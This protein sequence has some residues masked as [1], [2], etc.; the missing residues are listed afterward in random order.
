MKIFDLGKT[1]C[2]RFGADR[3]GHVALIFALAA[4]PMLG[5]VGLGI[6]YGNSLVAQ[7]RLNAAADQAALAGVSTSGNPTM[8]LP[9]Q[10]TIA[11][12][13]YGTAGKIP[14]VTITNLTVNASTSA[15]SLF[16]TVS[17]T[18]TVTTTLSQVMGVHS[19]TISGTSSAEEQVPQYISFYLLLDV[20]GSMGIPSTS[21]EIAR[22]AAINP[23]YLNL[24]PGGCSLACH[25]TAYKA[26][27]NKQGATTTCQGYNLSRTAGG[28]G[29][30]VSFCPQP[31][32]SSCIQLRLDAVAYAVQQLLSFAKQT[33]TLPNQFAVGLYPFI[34]YM[35]TYQALSTNLT[36]VSTAAGSLTT[37][38]DNGNG[39]SSLGS[40]GTHFENAL[41]ELNSVITK[42]GNGSS[43]SSPLPYVF[44]VTDGSQD[45]QYQIN[46]GSWSGSNSATT[47][48][49]SN[50]TLLKNRGIKIA[51][52]Y[53]PYVAIPN[54][55]T[56]WN[57]E[58]GYANAN[59]ANI[60]PSLE[61]CASPGF[62]FTASD[63][64]AITN[65]MQQ[66]FLA[67]VTEARLTK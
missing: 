56:I 55:T 38:I 16:V 13:F 40:G 42:V 23:D 2:R 53:T 25:F 19:F 61:A 14:Y 12:Y 1:L 8:A 60:P 59:I 52:L 20:S 28:T 45:N 17:Y 6:D 41:P 63:P 50:C 43:A 48:D 33:A 22:L 49:T 67:A 64:A 5:L 36:T 66:M 65:T 34:R 35:E 47:L 37:L 39:S 4:I 11:P 27:Q 9:T 44:M 32:T 15:T 3:S 29:T 30:P 57:N 21:S 54:P 7:S 31:G 46:N 18:A 26:C 62:F 51:V 58:D 10:A 24:Y